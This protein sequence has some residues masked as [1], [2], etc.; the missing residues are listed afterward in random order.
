MQELIMTTLLHFQ[1]PNFDIA[2]RHKAIATARAKTAV[3]PIAAP[4]QWMAAVEARDAIA[5]LHT[6][7][8]VDRFR[9]A[10]GAAHWVSVAAGLAWIALAASGVFS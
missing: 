9:A 5:R 1:A 4:K 8:A 3:A 2:R 6:D 7:I 10:C